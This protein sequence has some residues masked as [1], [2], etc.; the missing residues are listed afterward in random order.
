MAPI[1]ESAA[2]ANPKVKF[3]IVD[4]SYA[5]GCLAS[6]KLKNL[7]PVKDSAPAVKALVLAR[8]NRT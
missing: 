6:P 1:T 8:A 7:V 5:S 4:C 3:A 2:K